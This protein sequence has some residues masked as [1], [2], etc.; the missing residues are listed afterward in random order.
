M[1]KKKE[2][3][4]KTILD[5]LHMNFK[6][7]IMGSILL[8]VLFL[9]FGIIIYMNP[10]ITA[11]VVGIVIGIYFI[12]FGI[13]GIIEFFMRRDIPIFTFKIFMG[14]LAII[15][16]I[17][18]M[19]NPFGIVKIL[20]FALGLYLIFISIFKVLES[21]KLKKYGYDG[22]AL[23]LVISIILLV[24]GI[25]IT[26]NPMSSMDIIQVTGIFIILSSILEICNLIMVYS[27]E[28]DIVKLF[29]N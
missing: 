27:K 20:T 14:V 16:G 9:I 17:F 15:L 8:N 22:W 5:Y 18:I 2:N 6:K 23:M 25:F 10:Y 13:L 29:K 3:K 19:F 1:A 24:F 12:L 11:N 26:I 4:E 21:F 28:K 7:S